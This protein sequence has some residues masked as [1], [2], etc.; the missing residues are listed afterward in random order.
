MPNERGR[1]TFFGVIGGGLRPL[2]G[3]GKRRTRSVPEFG[4]KPCP[5]KHCAPAKCGF[6]IWIAR[7]GTINSLIYAFC[8]EKENETNFSRVSVFRFTVIPPISRFSPRRSYVVDFQTVFPDCFPRVGL[9][10]RRIVRP[11]VLFTHTGGFQHVGQHSNLPFEHCSLWSYRPGTKTEIQQI[12]FKNNTYN[13]STSSFAKHEFAL[14]WR[15]TRLKTTDLRCRVFFFF[16]YIPSPEILF[17]MV[18]FF[19]VIAINHA[20]RSAILF[21]SSLQYINTISV[22][23]SVW[24]CPPQPAHNRFH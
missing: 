9:L 8:S 15:A 16:L 4:S 10:N 14:F 1:E 6:G 20:M 3:G 24:S 5:D 23:F 2:V 13:I 18:F 7:P 21:E 19:F 11:P 22:P 12:S 17:R